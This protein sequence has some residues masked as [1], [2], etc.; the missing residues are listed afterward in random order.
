MTWRLEELE[1]KNLL[2][3]IRYSTDNLFGFIY[4]FIYLYT[5]TTLLLCTNNLQ[6]HVFIAMELNLG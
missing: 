3:M 6:V 4:L 2:I 5:I 1:Q